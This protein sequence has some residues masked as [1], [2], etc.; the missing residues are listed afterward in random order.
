M[1]VTTV[2]TADFL[3]SKR[4]GDVVTADDW[5]NVIKVFEAINK[6]AE[7]LLNVKTVVDKNTANIANVTL[8]S[9]PDRSIGPNKLEI[10]GGTKQVY[11]ITTD[12]T[13][14]PGV[15][16]YTL[17][18][19]GT[20]GPTYK[21]HE[22]LTSF[23]SGVAYYVLNTVPTVPAI[24]D[25][26]VIKNK[27]ITGDKLAHDSVRADNLVYYI[28]GHILNTNCTVYQRDVYKGNLPGTDNPNI[29]TYL[30]GVYTRS[31]PLPDDCAAA[32]V[33]GSHTISLLTLALNLPNIH[34]GMDTDGT[35]CVRT[36]FG[37]NKSVDNGSIQTPISLIRSDNN[38]PTYEAGGPRKLSG[39]AYVLV[40]YAYIRKDK[41]DGHCSIEVKYSRAGED[42]GVID[43]TTD[44]YAYDFGSLVIAL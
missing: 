31:I 40:D 24:S 34:I 5:N 37:G 3:Q 14:Q 7:E 22:G 17:D 41:T 20:N 33:I 10:S 43:R 42:F 9:V 1:A 4:E 39:S 18:T 25:L 16:Y 26:K 11:E 8:N 28:L 15:T 36:V 30:P 13:P 21:P 44:E 2:N 23:T 38:T 32:L 29:N 12:A 27:L 6:N 19:D 35:L